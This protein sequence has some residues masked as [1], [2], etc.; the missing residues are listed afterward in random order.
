ME[1]LLDL[2]PAA[3][4][5]KR[6]LTAMDPDADLHDTPCSEFSVSDLL[7]HC[8]GA[9]KALTDAAEQADSAGQSENGAD[10]SDEHVTAI[11]LRVEVDRLAT[12][13]SNPKLADV[14]STTAGG[15]TMHVGFHNMIAVQELVLHAWDLA[16]A[17][18]Q[19]YT[20]DPAT[21]DAL[22]EFLTTV[23]ADAPRDGSGPF[24]PVVQ[25]DESA[26]KLDQVLGL[27]GRDPHWRPSR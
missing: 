23:A 11:G 16:R 10:G 18:G 7:S 19:H 26:T 3:A 20:P 27:S 2:G 9:V 5:M 22:H 21:L 17:T 24:G 6:V 1:Q 14:D 15:V 4:G 12:A 25:V 13:W 8:R